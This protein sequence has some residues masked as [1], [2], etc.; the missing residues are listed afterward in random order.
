MV[1]KNVQGSVTRKEIGMLIRE[2]GAR[3]ILNQW[4]CC[5]FMSMILELSEIPLENKNDISNLLAM[6]EE[7]MKSIFAMKLQDAYDMKPILDGKTIA[8]ILDI[9]PGPQLGQ[10]IQDLVEWQ[11]QNGQVTQ[12]EAKQWIRTYFA[13]RI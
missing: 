13:R 4:D 6:Y 10:Y 12:D 2:L 8:G 7:F 11:L 1:R 3:P 9:K 5:I